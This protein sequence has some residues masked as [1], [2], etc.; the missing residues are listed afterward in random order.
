MLYDEERKK[1]LYEKVS[2]SLKAKERRKKKMCA[3]KNIPYVKPKKKRAKRKDNKRVERATVARFDFMGNVP[4]VMEYLRQYMLED[5]EKR[6]RK[7]LIRDKKDEMNI[8][9][10]D[11]FFLFYIYTIGMVNK[12]NA[13]YVPFNKRPLGS[14]R[15]RYYERWGILDRMKTVS[16]YGEVYHYK[17][18]PAYAKLMS[19]AISLLANTRK[20]SKTDHYE[21][22]F[23]RRKT[24]NPWDD[25]INE[26]NKQVENNDLYSNPTIQKE[27][28]SLGD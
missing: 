24:N 27:K 6:R 8:S 19:K 11:L 20:V 3:K 12:I 25:F 26:I 10:E 15:I 23:V 14:T 16:L 7:G 13:N 5:N 4:F 18:S 2:K 22:A 9:Y 21:L 28:K 1:N 17:L